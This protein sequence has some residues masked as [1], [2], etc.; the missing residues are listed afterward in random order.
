[1]TVTLA[2]ALDSIMAAVVVA[3]ER[4]RKPDG[5][6]KDVILIGRGDRDGPS[7]ETPSIWVTPDKMRVAD[8]EGFRQN[9]TEWWELPLRVMVMIRNE[10]PTQGYM[11]ATDLAARARAILLTQTSQNLG[12]PYL[13]WI[14]SS[15]FDPAGPWSREGEYHRAEAELKVAFSV[16]G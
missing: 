9:L 1:M 8:E 14:K 16:R 15:T 7:P 5:L 10:D 3:L 2:V 11:E 4:E 6:L 13:K 12:L